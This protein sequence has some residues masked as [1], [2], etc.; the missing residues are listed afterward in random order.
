M[1]YFILYVL[2]ILNIFYLVIIYLPLTGP[3]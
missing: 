2:T 1:M 3:L